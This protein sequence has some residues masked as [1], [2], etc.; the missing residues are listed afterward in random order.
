MPD[1]S[2]GLLDGAMPLQPA[3]QL[4]WTEEEVH[5]TQEPWSRRPNARSEQRGNRVRSS[6]ELDDEPKAGA[7][8]R[9]QYPRTKPIAP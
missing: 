8:Q 1:R 7:S 6:A 4:R 9:N 5:T 2:R 3:W